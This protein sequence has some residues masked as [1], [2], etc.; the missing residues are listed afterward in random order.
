MSRRT[1]EQ[2]FHDRQAQERDRHLGRQP[3]GLAFADDVYLNHETWIRPAF[4]R[5]G[6]VR[7]R[8]VLDYGCG[9]GMAAVVLARRGARVCAFDLSA[10]YLR[11]ARERARA[12]GATVEFVQADGEQMPF[13]DG[14][15]ELVWGNAVLHHLDT[16][17]AGRELYRVL[18]PGGV[19]VFCEPWG[20]N[21]LLNWARRRLPYPGKDRTADEQPLRQ[22]QVQRLR[23]MFPRV[24]VRGFQLLSM[25]RRA[26]GDCRLARGLSRCDDVLLARLP[27]LQRFCRYVVLTLHKAHRQRSWD[28]QHSANALAYQNDK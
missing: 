4:A 19:A 23:A 3:H 22:A 21:P 1:S 20:E 9:H 17:R 28:V 26:L 25:L 18:A 10:G 7:G 6:D 8:R 13:A 12:N 16:G 24:Q 27:G 5:L 11:E 15:F 14:S 2:I